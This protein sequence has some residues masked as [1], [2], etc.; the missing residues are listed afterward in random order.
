MYW[1]QDVIR[2]TIWLFLSNRMSLLYIFPDKNI[3][4]VDKGA[5]FPLKYASQGTKWLM[6]NPL[7]CVSLDHI[8]DQFLIS[9]RGLRKSKAE[10]HKKFLWKLILLFS[11]FPILREGC[12]IHLGITTVLGSV[13]TGYLLTGQA[14]VH[15]NYSSWPSSKPCSS[16]RIVQSTTLAEV[17][18][19]HRYNFN[20]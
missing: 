14:F 1:A 4:L 3:L 6:L 18:F 16:H 13:Y 19:L 11:I 2:K 20:C 7:L 17:N 12:C 8:K 10:I 15:F 9:S 5:A